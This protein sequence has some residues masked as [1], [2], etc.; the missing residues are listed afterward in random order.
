LAGKFKKRPIMSFLAPLKI[1][2]LV[3]VSQLPI[4]RFRLIHPNPVRV[5]A[6]LPRA[7]GHEYCSALEVGKIF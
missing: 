1:C 7:T 5:Q 2:E 4:Q 3:Q 6:S